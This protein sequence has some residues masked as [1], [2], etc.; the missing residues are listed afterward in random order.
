MTNLSIAVLTKTV[1]IDKILNTST[2]VKLE[3]V[4]LLLKA[5][6]ANR[7]KQIKYIRQRQSLTLSNDVAGINHVHNSEREDGRRKRSICDGYG[8]WDK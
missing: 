1:H 3:F 8:H 2:E 6:F 5:S 4:T 7:L